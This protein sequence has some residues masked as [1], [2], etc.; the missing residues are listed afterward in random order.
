MAIKTWTSGEVLTA[1]DL[2]TYA[3]NP[4]LVYITQSTFN[5]VSSVSVNNCFSATYANYRLVLA[6][7][8][9]G[10]T[11]TNIRWR[12]SGTDSTAT[13]YYD[14]GYYNL[15]GT[16]TALTNSA[17]TSSFLTNHPTSAGLASRASID[18]LGPNLAART[19]HHTMWAD[20]N[21]VLGGDTHSTHAVTTAYDGFT[22]LPGSG[23][24]TGT[25]WVFGYRQ[26]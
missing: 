17:Q 15:N 20:G 26:A 12:A 21:T 13:E 1:A 9:S 18:V 6:V 10:A 19:I 3:G 22:L 23:T 7:Y 24:I 16:L 4:G 11:T 14:R 2:N 8:G 5:G 25:V